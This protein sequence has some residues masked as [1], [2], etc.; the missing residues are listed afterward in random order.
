MI[1]QSNQFLQNRT[2]L[3]YS[4]DLFG[5]TR[6]YAPSDEDRLA[7]I[8]PTNGETPL[9]FYEMKEVRLNQGKTPIFSFAHPYLQNGY[10]ALD[11]VKWAHILIIFLLSVSF[12]VE[13]FLLWIHTKKGLG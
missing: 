8:Q 6:V 4:I 3:Y 7:M 11:T 5:F 9:F 13:A 1:N 2:E 12:L 10:P